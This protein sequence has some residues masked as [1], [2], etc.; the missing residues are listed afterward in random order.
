[1]DTKTLKVN[2]FE[3]EFGLFSWPQPCVQQLKRFCLD[4]LALAVVQVNGYSPQDAQHLQ[5]FNHTWFHITRQGGYMGSHN[6]PMASWS[7]VYCVATGGDDP[8]NPD[9]GVLRFH[10]PRNSVNMYMDAGNSNWID[11]WS[12]GQLSFKLKP[13]QLVMF[14]SFLMH[15]VATHSGPEE[16]ITVAFNCWIK[17][18]RVSGGP[19]ITRMDAAPNNPDSDQLWQ[20]ASNGDPEAQFQLGVIYNR[21][22]NFSRGR[23]WLEKSA[24]QDH[25]KALTELAL[26]YLHGIGMRPD[27]QQAAQLLERSTG[28]RGT[29]DFG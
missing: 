9:S 6:H 14:P 5:I 22:S 19:L 4:S 20:A 3:S 28:R 17:D 1:M 29:A 13:G 2:L 23:R 7:G 11:P 27:P 18:K 16:R 12:P 10:D 26:M 8:N 21:Q 25:G 15:E 24:R